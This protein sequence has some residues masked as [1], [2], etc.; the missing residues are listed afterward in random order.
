MPLS[1]S[2][3]VTASP[4]TIED[5]CTYAWHQLIRRLDDIDIGDGTFWWLHRVA[6]H[7]VW[8]L[9]AVARRYVLVGDV[10]HIAMARGHMAPSTAELVEQRERLRSLDELL[11]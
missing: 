10:T 9:T 3:S 1:R 2:R 11:P 6:V 8:R 4:E 5:A 7:E